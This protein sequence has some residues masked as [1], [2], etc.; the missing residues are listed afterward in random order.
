[1]FSWFWPVYARCCEKSVRGSPSP[2]GAQ[3]LEDS[4]MPGHWRT[5][6]AA[7][8]SRPW[9]P[10]S[11][12]SSEGFETWWEVPCQPPRARAGTR[13]VIQPGKSLWTFMSNIFR[14]RTSRMPPT[15]CMCIPVANWMM[16]LSPE[17]H[18]I[19]IDLSRSKN[20]NHTSPY[21]RH[22]GPAQRSVANFQDL[23]QGCSRK[24]PQKSCHVHDVHRKLMARSPSFA[25]WF[26]DVQRRWVSRGMCEEKLA[27]Y[28][29]PRIMA[30]CGSKGSPINLCQMMACVG[31]WRVMI[32]ERQWVSFSQEL[33][34]WPVDASRIEGQKLEFG[35]F[36]A[37]LRETWHPVEGQGHKSRWFLDLL[38][39]H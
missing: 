32:W 3:P 5:N 15:S 9:K 27:F 25:S 34:K 22:L 12:E 30:T 24:N 6:L 29:K 7:M 13:A 20:T 23:V 11:M 35:S 10:W 21:L 4:T 18:P 28:N 1:M 37:G 33:T 31:Q 38:L 8:Q 19:D 36:P 14:T 17:E 2:D 39:I 16:M 26:N